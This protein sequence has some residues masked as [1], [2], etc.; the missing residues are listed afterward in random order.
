MPLSNLAGAL[1]QTGKADEAVKICE[2]A[3]QTIVHNYGGTD[4]RL[5]LVLPNLAMMRAA[6]GDFAA[7]GLAYERVQELQA[8]WTDGQVTS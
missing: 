5:L 8:L 3:V 6:I 2:R 1:F 4:R 7:A